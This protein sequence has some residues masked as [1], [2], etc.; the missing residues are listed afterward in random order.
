MFSCLNK[1]Q[2]KNK[3]STNNENHS[4][5]LFRG[6]KSER[7]YRYIEKINTI[8]VLIQYYY[9]LRGQDRH[10]YLLPAHVF[11]FTTFCDSANVSYSKITAINGFSPIFEICTNVVYV[12][13]PNC[14]YSIGAKINC[15][16]MKVCAVYNYCTYSICQL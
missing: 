15:S 7:G 14:T 10:S 3:N 1:T 12:T 16:T 5:L 4:T 13:P 8:T 9:W 11:L 2:Q 6:R